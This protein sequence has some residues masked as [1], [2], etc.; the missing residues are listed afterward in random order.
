MGYS[1]AAPCR[2]H[3]PISART[4][5]RQDCGRWFI[6]ARKWK[7]SSARTFS[8]EIGKLLNRFAGLDNLLRRWSTL[9][10]EP[11]ELGVGVV[12]DPSMHGL[13]IL[14]GRH[15]AELPRHDRLGGI[16]DQTIDGF[17][18]AVLLG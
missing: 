4:F 11:F 3:C 9:E 8:W 18:F 12:A 16:V 1:P 5:S 6:A 14:A 7:S 17:D 13:T 10:T 15:A 2:A